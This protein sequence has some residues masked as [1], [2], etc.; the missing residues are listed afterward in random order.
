MTTPSASLASRP[1][2][3][4]PSDA[5]V[6][7]IAAGVASRSPGDVVAELDELVAR[8]RAIH[9]RRCVNLNPATNTMSPRAEAVLAAGLGTRPSL[10][11]P[12]A[13]YEMGLEAVERIE[14]IA[15]ELAAEVFGARFAEVRVP[16]G[17]LANLFGFMACA[18]PGDSI[19]V[20][21]ATIAGHV[22]HR[23]AGAAGLYGL[24]VHEAPIDADRYTIDVAALAPL[25][26]RVQPALI[27]VGSSLN[28]THHDVTGIRSVADAVGARVLFDA[29]HLAGPIAGGVWPRPLVEGAHLMT[30]STYKSLGGPP[31]GLIVTDDAALAE[32]IEA[33]AF[34]GL[35]ANFDVAKTAALAYTLADWRAT[36]A[37]YGEVM[38]AAADRLAAELADRDVPVHTAGGQATRSHA[39]AV[40]AS[41]HGGGHRGATHLRRANLLTSAIGLP[42][43]TDD[44]IRIGT[45]E[46]VRWG[47]TAD[48]M[49]PLADLL[50]RALV[51]AEPETVGPAVT[52]YRQRFSTVGFT[53]DDASSP[54]SRGGD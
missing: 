22:T 28:L 36:G 30:M 18:R 2:I 7:A 29:A 52:E 15:A 46:I 26:E 14:V 39:F 3:P 54:R 25:A 6:A 12:G 4:E 19:I 27:T 24:D 9:D 10:G 41:D 40:D 5:L 37:A 44:G 13:K 32:R 33:I 42:S 43:G 48:D 31:G 1:W 47:A 20:P 53:V 49:A 51:S 17:A 38:V 11:Y 8:N 35:T 50:Q 21:P 45:N 16:S 34:P 23:S